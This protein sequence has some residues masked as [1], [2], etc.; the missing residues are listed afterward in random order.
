MEELCT[1]K[2]SLN[3][4]SEDCNEKSFLLCAKFEIPGF[5][6]TDFKITKVEIANAKG[7][8][9]KKAKYIGKSGYY[10]MRLR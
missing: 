5:S 2:L 4:T 10:E 1:M 9:E 3:K 7:A 8:P 6:F